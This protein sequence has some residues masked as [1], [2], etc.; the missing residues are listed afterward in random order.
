MVHIGVEA[1]AHGLVEN[2]AKISAV[3]TK[4]GRNGLL[5]D[6]VVVVVGDVVENIFQLVV[7]GRVAGRIH[8]HL[9]LFGEELDDFIESQGIYIRQ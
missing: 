7:A 6:F 2:L 3:V 9:E 1:F 5:V 8:N 4:Q